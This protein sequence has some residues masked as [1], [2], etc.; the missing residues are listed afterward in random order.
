MALPKWSMKAMRPMRW[1]STHRG[2]GTPS[3]TGSVMRGPKPRSGS[4]RARHAA[5]GANTSRAWKVRL[6]GSRKWRRS[7][8]ACTC[9]AGAAIA[10]SSSPLSG[11]T[12]NCPREPTASGR[13]SVPTPGSTTAR[14]TVPGGKS[15]AEASST[16]AARARCRGGMSWVRSTTRASGQT[17]WMTPCTTPTNQSWWPK[18]DV[19]VTSG[20]AMRI[21]GPARA[22]RDACA[23]RRSPDADRPG[24]CGPRPGLRYDAHRTLAERPKACQPPRTGRPAAEGATHMSRDSKPRPARGVRTRAVHGTHA[25]A[26]GPM[27]TPIVHSATF[28][29]PSLAAMNAEQDRGPAGAYYHRV[30]HPTLHA[31]EERL[32]GIEGAEAGLLFSSGVAALAGMFLA[33][34]KSGDHAVALHQSYGGTHDL[35]HWG[36]E[37]FGW[38]VDFVDAREPGAWERA[39]RPETRLFHV[40]SPTNPTLCIVD[41]ERAARLA[42]A[43]G[44]RLTVDNTFASPVG[45]KA[46]ILGADLVMYSAT[47]SIGGHADLLAGA[48]LGSA[49][50]LEPV[51]K[52][53]KVFGP[54]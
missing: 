45:Q 21:P 49:Q 44:A 38:R 8:T 29:F 10:H 39:F 50:A 54:V 13:R 30:G 47:K 51:W 2:P 5:T 43:H 24:R 17:A 12:K 53:R 25:E 48:V 3:R 33:L 34:L 20:R 41:L 6:T 19:K 22:P 15:A 36:V 28:S 11:P 52:V 9:A 46:L 16:K 23:P 37:R 4:P 31:C 1:P 35:L 26:P 18:S 27:S 7:V 40:E 42:H 32:A 14:W